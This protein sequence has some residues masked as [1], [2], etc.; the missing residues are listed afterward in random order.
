MNVKKTISALLAILL[1][2]GA[3]LSAGCSNTPGSNADPSA[4]IGSSAGDA[5][6]AADDEP[7][8]AEEEDDPAVLDELPTDV[9]YEGFDYIVLSHEHGASSIAWQVQDIYTEEETGERINDAVFQRNLLMEDRFGVNVKE[10][11][12]ADPQGVA[13]TAVT[14]G[15]DEFALLQTHVQNLAADAINGWTLNMSALPY[16]NFEKA[17]WDTTAIR[18][19]TIAGKVYYAI[20]DSQL[21]AKKATWAVLFNKRLVNDAGIPDL[22]ETVKEGAWTIDLLKQ[23]GQQIMQDT[24][25]DGAMTWGEDVWGLGLQNEVV[26]P[27]LLGTGDQIIS[28][29][30]DGTYDYNLGSDRSLT[31]LE[32]VWDFMNTDADWIVNANDHG[33]ISNLWVEFRKLFMADKIG[34]YMGH[35]GTPTLVAG[36][37]ESDFGILPFPKVYAEQDGY[38]STFQYNNAHAVSIPKT[39]ADPEKIALLT[40]AY[41]MLAHTTILPAYYDYTLTL[42]AARDNQSGEML[43][44]IFANRNLDIALA[45]NSTTSLQ[46]TLE[47]AI[48]TSSFTFA[49]TEAKTT[50]AFLKAVEKV[51][52]TITEFE[53]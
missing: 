39:A 46:S 31:A 51:I 35:L 13:R 17:W 42:R 14:S 16:L 6:S 1:L 23:Y 38:Y 3:L 20:G 10:R 27:L 28:V 18:S 29:H 2:A 7:A 5:S 19:L 45:Y 30:E 32:K 48:Q 41:E 47:S 4:S 25:G 43:E 40:E 21:N 8:P 53:D 26:L 37:M 33:E 24:N 11:L 52:T 12:E 50:K 49:S 9:K 22:Y 15:A 34:F 36:D 44:L